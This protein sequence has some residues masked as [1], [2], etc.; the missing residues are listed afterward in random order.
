MW[1]SCIISGVIVKGCEVVVAAAW[2]CGVAGAVTEGALAED[3][4]L[5]RP[6]VVAPTF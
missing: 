3:L 6:V 4:D 2:G 1:T 5:A